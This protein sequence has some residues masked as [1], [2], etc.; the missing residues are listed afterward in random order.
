MAKKAPPAP[1]T[2]NPLT[3]AQ[4]AQLLP[5]ATM[6]GPTI[7]GLPAQ[8]RDAAREQQRPPAFVPKAKKGGKKR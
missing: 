5:A 2:G 7:I 4:A 6:L 1:R 8:I 3:T